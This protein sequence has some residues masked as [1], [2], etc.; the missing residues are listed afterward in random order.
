MRIDCTDVPP[1]SE[2]PE[3]LAYFEANLQAD[4][5]MSDDQGIRI[6]AKVK[7]F[8][9][10]V[11]EKSFHMMGDIEASVSTDLE[12]SVEMKDVFM[13]Y[14][15]L[16]DEEQAHITADEI[17]VTICPSDDEEEEGWWDVDVTI[18]TLV[19][20]SE[21]EDLLVIDFSGT[22]L[23]GYVCL[24]AP[25][26]AIFTST[27]HVTYSIERADGTSEAYSV[28][29]NSLFSFAMIETESGE[30]EFENMSISTS[31]KDF[32]FER[33]GKEA[34]VEVDDIT[35][36]GNYTGG[37]QMSARITV[38]VDFGYTLP[39][40]EGTEMLTI[41]GFGA[42]ISYNETDG[43][44][45]E[46]VMKGM[47]YGVAGRVFNMYGLQLDDEGYNI[48]SVHITDFG[49]NTYVTLYDCVYVGWFISTGGMAG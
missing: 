1:N 40:E 12:I 3:R 25:Y 29:M 32:Q 31:V 13:S 15:D 21:F 48:D 35:I 14:F 42:Y 5:T 19:L 7:S 10:G 34:Y 26:H 33:N 39:V 17:S 4:V 18:G 8:D 38:T 22:V 24:E 45:Y 28:V 9:I 6:A 23:K 27:E 20:D 37:E 2:E 44:E 49:K 11:L 46:A 16:E 36:S 43:L 47:T 41:S 30:Y